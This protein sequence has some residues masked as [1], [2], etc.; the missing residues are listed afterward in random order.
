MS[1]FCDSLVGPAPLFFLLSASLCPAS[2]RVTVSRGQARP[3]TYHVNG[4]QPP[5]LFITRSPDSTERAPPEEMRK[6]G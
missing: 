5:F 2:G 6:L 1:G 3:H 4:V